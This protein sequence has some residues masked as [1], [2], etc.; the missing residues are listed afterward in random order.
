MLAAILS[1][2]EGR[3]IFS[4]PVFLSFNKKDNEHRTWFGGLM[5]IGVKSLMLA[6]MIMLVNRMYYFEATDVS[7]VKL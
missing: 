6:Y 1:F 3:D 2:I 5:S 7:S 4:E